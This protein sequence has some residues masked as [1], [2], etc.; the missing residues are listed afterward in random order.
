MTRGQE[1]PV[2]VRQGRRRGRVLHRRRGRRLSR[3]GGEAGSGGDGPHTDV[4]GAAG[5]EAGGAGVGG[6][7]D[8]P[9]FCQVN[10]TK[11]EI[12]S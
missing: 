7:R 8:P 6:R 10:T 2:G 3:Q 12:G 9:V 5:R 4:A 1:P 11:E